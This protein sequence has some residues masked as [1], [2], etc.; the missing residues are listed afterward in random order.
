MVKIYAGKLQHYDIIVAVGIVLYKI[1]NNK[2]CYSKKSLSSQ[3]PIVTR[4]RNVSK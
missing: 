2:A 1:Q 3:I 4:W